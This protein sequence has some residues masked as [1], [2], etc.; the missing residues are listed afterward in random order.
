MSF[1]YY[2]AG[3]I[4][5]TVRYHELIDMTLVTDSLQGNTT[6]INIFAS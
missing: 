2:L 4:L 1:G 5:R 6:I 3:L